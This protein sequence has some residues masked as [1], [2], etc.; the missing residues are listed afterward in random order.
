[1]ARQPSRAVRWCH[2]ICAV[3]NVLEEQQQTVSEAQQVVEDALSQYYDALQVARDAI[4]E[5]VQEVIEVRDEYQE[6]Y[7]NL[8]ENLRGN[9]PVSEKLETVIELD[10]D[11]DMDTDETELEEFDWSGIED[12]LGEAENVELPMGF[13]RD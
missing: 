7:D 13:G 8:P 5:A 6:W 1:M 11:L 10:F 12:L 9:S 3:R 2:A 4:E